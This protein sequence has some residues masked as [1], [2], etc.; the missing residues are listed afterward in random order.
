MNLPVDFI[1]SLN[2]LLGEESELLLSALLEEAPVSI[3]INRFKNESNP[4]QFSASTGAVPWSSC[5]HYLESRPAFTF[6]PLFHAGHYYVQDASSMF[7]EH[8]TRVLVKS[9]AT[10]LDLCAAPGGKSLCLLSA[11]PRGSLLISNEIARVRANIL[12]ETVTKF[13]S[14]NVVVTNNSPKDFAPLPDFFD[15]V[16]VDAPC[17]GEGMFRKNES[18]VVEWSISN[19]EMCVARQKDILT[20][21]WPALKPGGILIY[22]TCTYNKEENEKI[23]SWLAKRTG[24]EFVSVP[25]EEV[26]GIYPS[27][28]SGVVGY[29][30]FPHKTKGEG[31]FVAI[32]R[33][34]DSG[35]FWIE[36][37]HTGLIMRSPGKNHAMG[38][39]MAKQAQ[40]RQAA[41][42][43][44]PIRF[45]DEGSKTDRDILKN[46]LKNRTFLVSPDQFDFMEYGHRF[47]AL[48]KK[49]S[50]VVMKLTDHLQIVS[51]GIGLGKIKGANFIP[52]HALA[53]SIE[54]DRNSFISYELTYKEAIAYLRNQAIQLSGV[55]KGFTLLTYMNEPIGFVKNIGNRAN[56]LYPGQWSI[57]SGYLPIEPPLLFSLP[58]ISNH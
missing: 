23:V 52:S 13:G 41:N 9:P 3:R 6:D 36:P 46:E 45:L 33:K 17:S 16:L 30:F 2:L 8:V 7:I 14:P 55:P 12:A 26:W 51:M 1:T 32:L 42:G 38:K 25:T 15:L 47:I 54:L 19:V 4:L 40:A 44:R 34:P 31:L 22:S 50:G 37:N 10:C 24:A 5:S 29:R 21:I 18:A 53:M 20:E 49:D 48:P 56:N 39:K 57:R 58:G 35:D 27:F 11:L 43:A 28:D